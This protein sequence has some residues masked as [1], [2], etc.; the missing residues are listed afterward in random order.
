MEL[1]PVPSTEATWCCCVELVRADSRVFQTI[2]FR[3]VCKHQVCGP[4]P[5][6]LDQ[7]RACYDA[8]VQQNKQRFTGPVAGKSQATEA[9]T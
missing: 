2:G 8:K 7:A 6:L 5:H 1:L 4:S 3:R 9:S